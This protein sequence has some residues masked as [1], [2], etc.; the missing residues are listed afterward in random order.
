M[1][2]GTDVATY[3][4]KTQRNLTRLQAHDNA[5]AARDDLA[6]T[7]SALEEKLNVPKRAARATARAKR[8]VQRF[9]GTLPQITE[10]YAGALQ[11][12]DLRYPNG[13]ALRVRGVTTTNDQ[14]SPNTSSNR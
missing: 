13:Y 4:K 5:R 7:L 2:A 11:T 12:V 3:D 9:V 1:A 14:T 10:R 8:R 6:R